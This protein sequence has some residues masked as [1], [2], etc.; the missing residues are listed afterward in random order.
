MEDRDKEGMQDES[1]QAMT[2]YA[3]VTALCV[4]ALLGVLS[5]FLTATVNFYE[6]LM[7]LIGLPAP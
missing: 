5:L 2:E 1:G 3:L 7:Y 6:D 4:V